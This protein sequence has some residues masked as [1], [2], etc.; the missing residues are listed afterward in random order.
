MAGT[1]GGRGPPPTGST[2][3][4]GGGGTPA[5]QGG[6][7]IQPTDTQGGDEGRFGDLFRVN[8]SPEQA[9]VFTNTHY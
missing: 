6:L 2:G 3:D 4:A 7:E 5:P 8:S 9:L 1:S